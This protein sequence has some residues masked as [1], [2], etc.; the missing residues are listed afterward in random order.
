MLCQHGCKSPKYG[1]PQY[2][3]HSSNYTLVPLSYFVNFVKRQTYIG[4]GELIGAVDAFFRVRKVIHFVD[5]AGAL[6]H[7]VNGYAWACAPDAA[8][9]INAF[10]IAIMA[11]EMRWYGEW[12]PSKANPADIMTRPERIVELQR[13][14]AGSRLP[15]RVARL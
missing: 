9:L 12:V 2:S 3:Y 8:R 4:V 1:G 15:C 6:S 10:H 14:L 13:A 11:L 5:N 7:M